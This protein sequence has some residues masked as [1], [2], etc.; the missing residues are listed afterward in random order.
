MLMRLLR[1][2][3][4]AFALA[5]NVAVG[6]DSL[7]ALR[8]DLNQR[9]IAELRVFHM[10]AGGPV[11]TTPERLRVQSGLTCVVPMTD[12]LLD[13]L[14]GA[15]DASTAVSSQVSPDVRWGVDFLDSRGQTWH[16]LARWLERSIPSWS[17]V[18]REY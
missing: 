18:A 5:S 6:A 14:R 1:P 7:S 8:R 15:L 12:S 9:K 3:L 11:L 13:G 17:C 4:I 2:P 10:E 16:A